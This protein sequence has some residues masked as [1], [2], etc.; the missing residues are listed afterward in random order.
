M[1]QRTQ[2]QLNEQFLHD[3]TAFFLRGNVLNYTQ[4][5]RI[6]KQFYTITVPRLPT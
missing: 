4:A 3:V 6:K 1:T 2:A 5:K